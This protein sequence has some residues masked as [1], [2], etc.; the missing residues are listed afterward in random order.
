MW[1]PPLAPGG[2]RNRKLKSCFPS[3][4]TYGTN[5]GGRS[6]ATF[7]MMRSSLF[8]F[9]LLYWASREEGSLFLSSPLPLQNTNLIPLTFPL[10]RRSKKRQSSCFLSFAPL[11]NEQLLDLPF[12]LP[13][14]RSS[15]PRRKVEDGHFSLLPVPWSFSHLPCRSTPPGLATVPSFFLPP[16]ASTRTAERDL[17]HPPPFSLYLLRK[18][19]SGNL[20]LPRRRGRPFPPTG[21]KRLKSR[22]PFPLVVP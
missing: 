21:A 18:N 6:V 3:P 4:A 10:E 13:P 5:G 22:P 19:L 1:P 7:S 11:T 12:L 2:D 14:V 9:F 17:L 20:P 16:F 15:L 8:L